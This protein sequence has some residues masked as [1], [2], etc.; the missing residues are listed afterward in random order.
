MVYYDQHCLFQI[1]IYVCYDCFIKSDYK[2]NQDKI[3]T[4]TVK[5]RPRYSLPKKKDHFV[6]RVTEQRFH[7][8]AGRSLKASVSV[9]MASS[10]KA[11]MQSAGQGDP[12]GLKLKDC[13]QTQQSLVKLRRREQN[14]KKEEPKSGTSGGGAQFA[15]CVQSL[16]KAIKETG[17]NLQQS[18]TS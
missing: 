15:V 4:N 2:A 7:M 5:R 1:M 6:C 12:P 18:S 9:I 11:M 17:L 8:M 10:V 14:M 3:I 13:R 16:Y